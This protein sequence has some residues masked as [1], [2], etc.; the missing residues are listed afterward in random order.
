M[1][2]IDPLKGR[3]RAI[4]VHRPKP[5]ADKSL[6]LYVEDGKIKG[7]LIIDEEAD[8]AHLRWFVLDPTMRGK[9]MGRQLIKEALAFVDSRFSRSDLWTFSG[10]D[11]A[12]HLMSRAALF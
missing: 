4:A 9:G 5:H 10:L 1:G 6:W 12:R 2:A 7:S 11:A 8:L 3:C